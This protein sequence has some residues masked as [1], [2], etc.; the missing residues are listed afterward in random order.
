[1]KKLMLIILWSLIYNSMQVQENPKGKSRVF[2]E[3]GFGFAQT[4]FFGD[5]QNQLIKS[6]GGGF[7]PGTGNNLMLGFYIA[8]EKW[9]GFGLGAR[10]KGTF[11]SSVK[12]DMGDSYIFNYY[13]ISFSA[14]YY[15]ISKEFNKGL[16]LRGWVGFGQMTTK[17]VN[18][19]TKLYKHQYAIG[20]TLMFGLGWTFPLGKVALSAETEFEYSNRRGTADG[21]GDVSYQSG[22]LGLNVIL[23]F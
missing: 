2:A 20:S 23:S 9:K 21:I 19:L 10:V 15:L 16:Y 4:L 14:K 11:G 22:Q 3:A 12:G 7:E 17:R 5:M 6:Y 8:P 18:E 13:T 1:M